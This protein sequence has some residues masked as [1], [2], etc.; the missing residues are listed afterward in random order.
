MFRGNGN[1]YAAIG[2]AVAIVFGGVLGEQRKPENENPTA[3]ASIQPRPPKTLTSSNVTVSKAPSANNDADSCEERQSAEQKG[4]CIQREGVEAAYQSA[5]WAKW[6]V[7]VGAAG[8]VVV[9]V[10][11]LLSGAATRAAL[12]AARYARESLFNERAWI[13]LGQTYRRKYVGP[14]SLWN[15]EPFQGQILE[16]PL[17]N[18]G[19][20]PAINIQF[21]A[22][23]A[24]E[25]GPYADGPRTIAYT[26]PPANFGACA[27]GVSPCI[28]RLYLKE[29]VLSQLR[30]RQITAFCFFKLTY[31]DIFR[32]ATI[33][34]S[35]YCLRITWGGQV[36]ENG[37]EP[38]DGWEIE[39]VPRFDQI[40]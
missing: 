18:F 17:E 7:I 39:N 4:L 25:A 15:S 28:A 5:F 26:A 31:A 22:G 16:F 40:S 36:S 14:D 24:L 8:T 1:L 20:S 12:D 35:Q 13:F 3:T 29:D 27:P 2:I 30:T 6:T 9:A 10:T 21:F 37:G 32:P 34:V 38:V 33:R 19:K 23:Q 11:L